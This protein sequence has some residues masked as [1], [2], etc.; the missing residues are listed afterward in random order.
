MLQYI[1]DTIVG[2]VPNY[3]WAILLLVVA[4]LVAGLVKKLVNKLLKAVSMKKLGEKEAS[5]K[6]F[7]GKV[8]YLIIF[9]LFLPKIFNLL[10]LGNISEP[11]ST[12]I[13]QLVNFIPN[14][15]G[16]AITLAIGLFIAKAVKDLL[17]PLFKLTKIDKL[18]EKA[19][20]EVTEKN[21][22]S[23]V[24][25]NIA[26]VLILLVVITSTLGYLAIPAISQPLNNIVSS[27]FGFIPNL[28]GAIVVIAVGLFV[29]KLAANLLEN[30]LS[31]IGTDKLTEKFCT[32]TEKCTKLSKIIAVIVKVILSV[33]IVI[34]GLNILGLPVLANLG[35]FVLNY[36]PMLLSVALIIV[37][38]MFAA[39]AASA[40]VA[41]AKPEC[42]ASPAIVKYA[43]YVVAG[44]LALSQLNIANRIVEN[45][46][47]LLVAA[48]CVAVAIAFGI[49]GKNYAAKLLE[50]LEKK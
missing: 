41:K 1:L 22:L 12:L 5:F 37:A 34:Q 24:L 50:K 3:L 7:I 13:H 27:I 25:A 20:I 33:V 40:A 16:A 11:I 10:G 45:T 4:F 14:L 23:T 32:K 36:I 6:S 26:Y 15:V 38:A 39:N 48:V 47:I 30:L 35:S 31:S 2:A 43:I 49:G 42:K 21:A 46:F 29:V 17:V 19:G 8:V 44:F 18:Q 28:L 9:A